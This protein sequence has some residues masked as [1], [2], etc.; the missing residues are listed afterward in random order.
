MREAVVVA[1]S[2]SGLAKSFRG[3]FNITRPDDVAAHCVKD[4]LRKVP[5]LDQA[6]V[7]DVV[8]GA[9]FPEGRRASTSAGTWRCW[10][11]SPSPSPAAP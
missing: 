7:D 1:S 6:E 11:G 2:R 10:R 8:M 3:S 5:Q 4:V 9:G